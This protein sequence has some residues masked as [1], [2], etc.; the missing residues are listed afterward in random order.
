MSCERVGEQHDTE[1]LNQNYRGGWR[2]RA[3]WRTTNKQTVAAGERATQHTVSMFENGSGGHIFWNL[4]LF[5]ELNP[6][7]ERASSSM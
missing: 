2:G 1:K 5:V 7:K 6:G 4:L 3:G